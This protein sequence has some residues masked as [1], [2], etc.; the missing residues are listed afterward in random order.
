M[1]PG[2]FQKTLSQLE[3]GTCAEVPY[4]IFEELFPPGVEDDRAKGAA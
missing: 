1:T 2:E 3:P 4:E